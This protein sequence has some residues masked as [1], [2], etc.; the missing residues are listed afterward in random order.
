MH[1]LTIFTVKAV[2]P[3]SH[4]LLYLKTWLIEGQGSVPLLML[5]IPLLFHERHHL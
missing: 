3:G 4:V 2:L 5:K 1:Q